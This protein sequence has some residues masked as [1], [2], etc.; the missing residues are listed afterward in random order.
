MAD[1]VLV[2]GVSSSVASPVSAL[3]P[4][5]SM[6][7]WF[8]IGSMFRSRRYRRAIGSCLST[9]CGSEIRHVAISWWVR[10]RRNNNVRVSPDRT[11]RTA[12][13]SGFDLLTPVAIPPESEHLFYIY[14]DEEN[15]LPDEKLVPVTVTVRWRTTGRRWRGIPVRLKTSNKELKDLATGAERSRPT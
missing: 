11:I 4:L 6:I 12:L 13:S 15:I 3:P 5:R 1:S 8:V 2:E 9:C 14:V 10:L 7:V